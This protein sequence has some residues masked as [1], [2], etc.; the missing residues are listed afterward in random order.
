MNVNAK[1]KKKKKPKKPNQKKEDKKIDQEEEEDI[2]DTSQ[3]GQGFEVD[4]FVDRDIDNG[5]EI[6]RAKL[7]SKNRG[8]DRIEWSG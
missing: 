3:E 1:S 8:I 4:I 7:A 5:E 2:S 6:T